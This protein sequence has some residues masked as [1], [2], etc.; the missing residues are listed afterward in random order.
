MTMQGV[1]AKYFSEVENFLIPL[2]EKRNQRN[3][4]MINALNQ[5]LPSEMQLDFESDVLPLSEAH[6]GGSVTERHLMYALLRKLQK[7]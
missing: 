5:R 4:E 7:N 6:D 1:A 3:K 2:R